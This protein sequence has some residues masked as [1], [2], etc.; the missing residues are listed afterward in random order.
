VQLHHIDAALSEMEYFEIAEHEIQYITGFYPGHELVA[1]LV[2]NIGDNC[3]SSS[4]IGVSL[5]ILLT[6]FYTKMNEIIGC[7]ECYGNTEKNREYDIGVDSQ[8]AL[9]WIC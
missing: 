8:P 2:A 7:I 5:S 3:C 9:E 1:R 4:C 6:V